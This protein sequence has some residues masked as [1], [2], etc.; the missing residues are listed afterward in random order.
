MLFNIIDTLS[1]FLLINLIIFSYI[2]YGIILFK[3]TNNKFI[4]L[5]IG[6]IGIAGCFLLIFLSYL[7]SFFTPHNSLHNI[8]VI[9]LGILFFLINFNSFQKKNLKFLILFIILTF[10]FFLIS[11]T[12]DDFGYYHLPYALNLSENK[13]QFGLGN[14]NY[15]F[16]HH[17]SILFLNS[18]TFL[19]EIKYYLFNLPSYLIYIFV[20][21]ILI[22]EI[23]KK[24]NYNI[25]KLF[26]I[27]FIILINIKFVR[28]AEYGTDLA[29]QLV[30]V[31]LFLNIIKFFLSKK[32]DNSNLFLILLILVLLASFKVYF[33]LY[34]SIFFVIIYFII[35]DYKNI[36]KFINFRIFTIFFIFLFLISLHNYVSTGCLVYPVTNL[37]VGEYFD[38]S[39][40]Y[41]DIER[42]KTWLHLWSKAGA[43]PDY[44]VDNI[45]HYISGLNWVPNWMDKYFF[46]KM[47][48][49][50]LTLLFVFFIIFFLFKKIFSKHI[51]KRKDYNKISFLILI[52]SFSFVVFWFFNHPSLRYGGYIPIAICFFSIISIFIK[53]GNFNNK[54]NKKMMYCI[55][56]AFFVFNLKNLNRIHFEFNRTDQFNFKNFPYF[57]VPEKEF[58][59]I[60]DEKKVYLN[61]AKHHCWAVPSPCSNTIYAIEKNRGFIFFKRLDK[62]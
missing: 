42:L 48:D 49:Y 34:F 5:N 52:F 29:G 23:I 58:K 43:G 14:L 40:K 30:L 9:F 6:Y 20:N 18:L 59:P 27:F 51:T 25:I 41:N 24:N 22:A 17:S 31:I 45:D 61:I 33:I 32:I 3:I 50:L 11:K 47:S 38:W 8:I 7:T 46:N 39:L 15:A 10:S 53:E 62:K 19:P 44:K 36:F 37:C 16:R 26:S 54:L 57:F 2:G 60:Y 13:I 55:I 1:I 21:L 28:L 12:H 56:F 4:N 35:K